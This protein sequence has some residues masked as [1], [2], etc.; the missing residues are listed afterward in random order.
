MKH[1]PDVIADVINQA[2]K[3]A[4]LPELREGRGAFDGDSWV[5][6]W[7]ETDEPRKVNA[8]AREVL[9]R[10]HPDALEK[11]FEIEISAVAWLLEKRQI[12]EKRNYYTRYVEIRT[13][14]RNKNELE[15]QIAEHLCSASDG[16]LEIAKSLPTLEKRRNAMQ[17]KM[18]EINL[19]L[20]KR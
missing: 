19:E 15:S 10:V 13:V 5:W 4:G 12:A 7:F 20:T 11:G 9:V 1:W 6:A 2:A 17:L 16:A 14:G 8:S 3:N 18:D